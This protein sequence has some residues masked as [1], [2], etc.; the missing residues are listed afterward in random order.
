MTSF[1]GCHELGYCGS[2]HLLVLKVEMI[3]I[4]DDVALTKFLDEYVFSS[5][6]FD[7]EA[8]GVER[9]EN[10]KGVR[11]RKEGRGASRRNRSF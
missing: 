11:V 10:G 7:S 2:L 6:R 3:E 9:D 8:S 1:Q 5:S 4:K